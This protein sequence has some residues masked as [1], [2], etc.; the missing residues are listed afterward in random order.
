MAGI[1]NPIRNV[2]DNKCLQPEGQSTAVFTLIVQATC[3]GSA[4]QNWQVLPKGSN[5][6]SFINQASSLCLYV[7]AEPANGVLLSQDACIWT[8]NGTLA[9]FWVVGG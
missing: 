2:G 7:T 3:D 5:H 4:A 6:Y 9:Q 8:C 1:F